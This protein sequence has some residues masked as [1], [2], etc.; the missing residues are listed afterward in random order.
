[1]NRL[2]QRRQGE[3]R[4]EVATVIK[5]EFTLESTEIRLPTHVKQVIRFAHMVP[6]F[7]CVDRNTQMSR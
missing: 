7:V 6:R 4:D 1:M 3:L 2:S 5:E